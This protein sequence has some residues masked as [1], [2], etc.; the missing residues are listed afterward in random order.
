[1]EIYS[2]NGRK[3]GT[4]SLE[5]PKE[6]VCDQTVHTQSNADICT[7]KLKHAVKRQNKSH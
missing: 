7:V 2:Q 1:M 4:D 3:T 6:N 5:T